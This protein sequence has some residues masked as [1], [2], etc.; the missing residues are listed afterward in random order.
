M[1]DRENVHSVTSKVALKKSFF[2]T[3]YCHLIFTDQR[4]IVAHYDPGKALD[5]YKQQLSKKT[6]SEDKNTLL[7]KVGIKFR[8]AV[9]FHQRYLCMTPEEIVND[10]P[11]NFSILPKDIKSLD[12]LKG[13]SCKDEDGFDTH[14]PDKLYIVLKKNGKKNFYIRSCFFCELCD[15]LNQIIPDAKINECRVTYRC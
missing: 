12:F 11:A 1:T 8:S 4:I 5:E 9:N 3:Q 6:K 7:L 10:D 2:N 15:A 13:G 14:N